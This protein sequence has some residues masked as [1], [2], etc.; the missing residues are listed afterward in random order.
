MM[1]LKKSSSECVYQYRKHRRGKK[2]I[3]IYSHMGYEPAQSADYD[4]ERAA[5]KMIKELNA[6]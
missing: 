1:T 6:K 5:Q 2:V 4:N 3:A